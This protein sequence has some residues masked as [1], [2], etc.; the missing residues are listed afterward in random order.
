M[1]GSRAVVH[2]FVQGVTTR[3]TEMLWFLFWRSTI[4]I[5]SGLQA[6]WQSYSMPTC[7]IFLHAR[8]CQKEGRVSAKFVLQLTE[9]YLPPHRFRELG[10]GHPS[11]IQSCNDGS[12]SSQWES[13]KKGQMRHFLC[14][15]VDVHLM[16]IRVMHSQYV[17]S[18]LTYRGGNSRETRGTSLP[19]IWQNCSS[20]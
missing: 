16:Y 5:F 18:W 20:Q 9:W 14:G 19:Y 6:C 10:T 17:Q 4:W 12:S 15:C 8:L 2:C 11:V 3:S 13:L 7:I 1:Q